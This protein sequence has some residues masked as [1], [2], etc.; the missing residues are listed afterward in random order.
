MLQMKYLGRS[1]EALQ[2][3]EDISVQPGTVDGGGVKGEPV[4][5]AEEMEGDIKEE[6]ALMVRGFQ[7]GGRRSRGDR[8]GRLS[9]RFRGYPHPSTS[10]IS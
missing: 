9:T 4:F 7:Q 2:S 1:Y 6:E 10:R 8:K 3:I 5:L